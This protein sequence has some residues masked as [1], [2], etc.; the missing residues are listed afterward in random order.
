VTVSQTT[1]E[2]ANA[3]LMR[4]ENSAISSSDGDSSQC[5]Q[6]VICCLLRSVSLT[7]YAYRIGLRVNCAGL[8]GAR[9]APMLVEF[10]PRGDECRVSAAARLKVMHCSIAAACGR[11]AVVTKSE[12]IHLRRSFLDSI[13]MHHRPRSRVDPSCHKRSAGHLL[14][15]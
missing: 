10:Q 8:A 3:D 14:T 4:P 2:S 13:S 11:S 15:P 6:S 7:L 5:S 12:I 9:L 1:G